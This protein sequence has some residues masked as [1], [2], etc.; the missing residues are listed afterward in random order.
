V[1]VIRLY[2]L[3]GIVAAL[4]A[5]AGFGY[6]QTQR[7]HRTQDA[8]AQTTAKYATC[9]AVRALERAAGNATDDDLVDGLSRP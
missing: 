7:L 9:A 4:A 3:G 8:L 1:E 5:S 2:L 6:V